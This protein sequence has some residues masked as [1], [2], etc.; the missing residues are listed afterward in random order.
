VREVL[1]SFKRDQGDPPRKAAEVIRYFILNAHY[2]SPLNYSHQHLVDARQALTG[3]YIALRD[4]KPAAIQIDWIEPRAR[5]FKDAMDDDFN[6]P[7]ALA[8]LHEI[9]TEL[10]RSRSA[11]DAGLLKALG[12]VLGLL[13][14]PPLE[15]LQGRVA[16]KFRE[17]TDALIQ[18]QIDARN[19]ARKAKNFTEADRIR[20]ELSDA[21]IVLEDTPLGT[22]WRSG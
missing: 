2:R 21:G 13:Q 8:V 15:F 3:L 14:Q 20:K 4:V 6:T 9:A 10:N 5:R 11:E 17:F 12:A 18:Q 16:E 19:A 7:E 22:N 1:D